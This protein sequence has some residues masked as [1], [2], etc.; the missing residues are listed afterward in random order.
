M[1]R[2][3]IGTGRLPPLGVC[4]LHRG[5]SSNPLKTHPSHGALAGRLGRR[6]FRYVTEYNGDP[7]RYL[8]PAPQQQRGEA[9][10]PSTADPGLRGCLAVAVAPYGPVADAPGRRLAV[11]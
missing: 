9:L 8:R 1:E 3:P 11:L 2:E 6:Q 4:R 5:R 10:A 7:V